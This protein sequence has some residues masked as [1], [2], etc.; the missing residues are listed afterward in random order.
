MIT[1]AMAGS[2]SRAVWASSSPLLPGIW[3]S[4]RNRSKGPCSRSAATAAA[5][6]V[7]AT[8]LWPT[9]LRARSQKVD[10]VVS[11]SAIRT[12]AGATLPSWALGE[13]VSWVMQFTMY[14]CCDARCRSGSL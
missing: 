13:A 2:I 5:D 9:A 8:T 7:V 10:M 6:E 14:G 1:T 4:A 11:S 12:R 3:M